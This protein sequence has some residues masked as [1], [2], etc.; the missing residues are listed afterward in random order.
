MSSY[1]DRYEVIKTLGKGATATVKLVNDPAT[2]GT[3][4]AKILKPTSEAIA[5]RFRDVMQ[6]EIASLQRISHPNIVN[7]IDCNESGTYTRK[8]GET[9]SCFYI[10]MELCPNGE[11]FDMIYNTGKFEESIARFY[12]RQII[13]GLEAC[14]SAGISHRDMKPE[15]ILFSQDFNLKLTDFGFSIFLEGRGGDHVL[16]TRLGTEG[17]MAPEVFAGGS[18]EGTSVDIFSTGIILFI[19]YSH[20]PPFA[21]ADRNDPFYRM[22]LN[23]EDR[24]WSAHS[25]N[26]PAGHYTPE[27]KD[28]LKRM[29]LIDPQQRITI[30]QIK[31]HPWYNGAVS[32]AED[33]LNEVT[34]RRDKVQEAA[35]RARQQRLAMT[36]NRPGIVYN[37]GRFFRGE[38][39]DTEGLML[40]FSLRDDEINTLKAPS[41]LLKSGKYSS[42]VTGLLPQEIMKIVSHCLADVEAETS[43]FP[44]K[45]EVKAAVVTEDANVEFVA[46]CFDTDD[47]LFVFDMSLVEGSQFEMMKIFRNIHEKID[48]AQEAN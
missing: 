44:E 12:F 11:L 23:Q 41:G 40:S 6:N 31:E 39:S 5:S 17:Y 21:K 18:Y 38:M 20:N 19:M 35:E 29:L 33:I 36:G 30:E 34:A 2:N 3:F 26:K 22:L 28:L 8:S 43:V 42:V 9:Y 47:E 4:A 24:F 48:E 46:R 14:H 45:C 16:R 25:R 10:L 15:N 1:L 7:L 27:F 13:E 32:S 37:Q